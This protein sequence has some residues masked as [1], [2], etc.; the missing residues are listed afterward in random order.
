[1]RVPVFS[2]LGPHASVIVFLIALMLWVP[3]GVRAT[4]SLNVADS[5][6]IRLNRGFDA[7]VEKHSLA[8]DIAMVPVWLHERPTS[9]V[10]V[11]LPRHDDVA[12]PDSVIVPAPEPLRGPPSPPTV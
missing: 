4:Q 2:R 10:P 11:A 5:G 7:P 9:S 1:M 6:S 12:L 8:A 3:V